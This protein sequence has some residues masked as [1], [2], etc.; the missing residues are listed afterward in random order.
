MKILE[1]VI[2]SQQLHDSKNNF[3]NNCTL[4]F[5]TLLPDFFMDH[6]KKG[7]ETR[8]F[9][10]VGGF[11][12]CRIQKNTVIEGC[13]PNEISIHTLIGASWLFVSVLFYLIFC[14]NVV[15]TRKTV[16]RPTTSL[17]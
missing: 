13:I 12:L 4:F 2:D 5:P 10:M 16:Q 11:L 14:K 15:C 1:G 6:L 7:I 8:S 17:L 3:F 9:F